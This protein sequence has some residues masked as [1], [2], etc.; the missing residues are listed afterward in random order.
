MVFLATH[1]YRPSSAVPTSRM[2]R[3]P[4]GLTWNFPL[5]VTCTP[6]CSKTQCYVIRVYPLLVFKAD[7]F[8][9]FF[10]FFFLKV[11]GYQRVTKTCPGWSSNNLKGLSIT[12]IFVTL[13]LLLLSLKVGI[14]IGYSQ[15]IV[16]ETYRLFNVYITGTLLPY[17]M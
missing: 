3:Y 12:M 4:S 10:F 15:R 14:L 16:T 1:S 5:S 7:F 13:M 6:S 9:L 2:V 17:S 11:M 8:K